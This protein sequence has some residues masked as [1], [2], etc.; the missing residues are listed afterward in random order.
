L[1]EILKQVSLPDDVAAALQGEPG[2]MHDALSLA[3]AVE[4]ESPQEIATA[5]ALL[6]LDAP[7]VT[8]LMLEALDWAQ[9]VVSA[10]N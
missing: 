9:H 5:A 7:E 10:G 6:G 4:S 1:A 2:A 8:A 3:I